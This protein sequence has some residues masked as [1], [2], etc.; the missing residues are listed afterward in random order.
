MRIAKAV[1]IAVVALGI[2]TSVAAQQPA[3]KSYKFQST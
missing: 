3:A 2:A 1:L